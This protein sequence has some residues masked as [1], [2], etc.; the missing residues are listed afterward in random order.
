MVAK[1]RYMPTFRKGEVKTRGRLLEVVAPTPKP[2]K[3][4][5]P[6]YADRHTRTLHYG[7]I[8]RYVKAFLTRYFTE[9]EAVDEEA[10]HAAIDLYE[11]KAVIEDELQGWV[12]NLKGNEPLYLPPY[13]LANIMRTMEIKGCAFD[14]QV[15]TFRWMSSGEGTLKPSIKLHRL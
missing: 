5:Y 2:P 6:Q 10:S 11:F 15:S 7:E 1:L 4:F 12:G 8:V 3:R 14:F 13:R 9:W